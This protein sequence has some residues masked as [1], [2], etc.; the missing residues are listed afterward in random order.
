MV[1]D[2]FRASI[3]AAPDPQAIHDLIVRQDAVGV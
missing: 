2:E 3:L 1:R